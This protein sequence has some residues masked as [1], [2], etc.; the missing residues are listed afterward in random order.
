MRLFIAAL[1]LTAAAATHA[2]PQHAQAP[3][4]GSKRNGTP[5]ASPN[6]M[7]SAQLANA[8]RPPSLNPPDRSADPLLLVDARGRIVGRPHAGFFNAPLVTTR[9]QGMS[10]VIDG[11]AVNARCDAASCRFGPGLDWYP[12]GAGVVVYP[13]ADCSG[14][15]ELSFPQNVAGFD[16]IALAV[17]DTDGIYLYLARNAPRETWVRSYR[18]RAEN[19]CI[20]DTEGHPETTLPVDAVYPASQFGTPPMRWR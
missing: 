14:P 12:S 19:V 2:Q 5:V 4:Q 9:L 8:S 3:G 16:A 18:T 1:A 15:P 6:R 17:N 13:S 10:V 11:L 20:S 7:P